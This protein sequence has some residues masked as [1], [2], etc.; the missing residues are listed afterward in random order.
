MLRGADGSVSP[1]LEIADDGRFSI[2]QFV[3]GSYV[4]TDPSRGI[5]AAVAGWWIKSIALDGRELLDAPLELKPSANVIVTLSDR[6][7]ELSGVLRGAQ[8]APVPEQLVIAFSTNRDHWF[9]QSRRVTGALTDAGGA[10]SIRNLPAGDY[11]VATTA[12]LSPNEWFNPAVL[13]R[14]AHEAQPI[15]LRDFEIRTLDLGTDK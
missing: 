7:S 8:G 15:T 13:E 9:H 4:L 12:G 1:F 2:S 3:P 6:A 10:Y 5:R 14:L 11:L